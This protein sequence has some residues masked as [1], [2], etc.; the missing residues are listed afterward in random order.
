MNE[1]KSHKLVSC[2]ELQM[3]LGGVSRATVWRYWQGP[4][5]ILPPPLKV[6]KRKIAWLEADVDEAI[7]RLERKPVGV[8]DP[9]AA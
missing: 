3:R 5:A 1:V 7:E 8:G 9:S 6:G 4:A 2:R